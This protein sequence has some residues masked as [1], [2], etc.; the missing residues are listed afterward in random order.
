M[1]NVVTHLSKV[2]RVGAM[3]VVVANASA[4]QTSDLFAIV[5]MFSNAVATVW[6]R[7]LGLIC[8]TASEQHENNNQ[9]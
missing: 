4:S 2:D 1:A 7:G 9:P 6:A 3:K 5:S 8:I